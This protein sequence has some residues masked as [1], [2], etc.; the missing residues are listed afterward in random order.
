MKK[1]DPARPRGTFRHG[2]LRNALIR[3]GLS[4]ARAGGPDAVVLREATRQAG[5][6]PNAAYRHFTSQ[7][8]LL[9]AVR[10]ACISRLAAAIEQEMARHK[11]GRNPRLYARRSLCAVGMGY[12]G[13]ALREPGMFR[14]AFSVPPAIE[15]P[16]QANTASMGLNP[17]QLLSLALDRMQQAGLLREK[18]REG[19]EFLAWSSVHGLALLA[20][21]GPLLSMPRA[22]V[23]ALGQRLVNMVER[24]LS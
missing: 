23:L 15:T 11:P 19:A 3:A 10:S 9:D 16:N 2:D 6:A 13:F 5:V 17:Y 12:L 21:E 22:T 4:M 1:A 18:D 7:A 14:T 8:A 20:L 24:G